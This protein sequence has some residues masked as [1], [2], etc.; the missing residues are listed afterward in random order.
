MAIRLYLLTT[1]GVVIS[2]HASSNP[3]S[4][5]GYF[6]LCSAAVMDISDVYFSLTF[7]MEVRLE[8]KNW[9]VNARICKHVHVTIKYGLYSKIKKKL[10]T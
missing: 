7:L 6:S 4:V 10:P 1:V 5:T 8:A 9:V 2:L 3:F